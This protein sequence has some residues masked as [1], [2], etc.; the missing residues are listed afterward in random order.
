MRTE[1][2]MFNVLKTSTVGAYHFPIDFSYVKG[3]RVL[4]QEFDFAATWM[5]LE[6]IILSELSQLGKDKYIAYMWNIKK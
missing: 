3:S 6:F 2:R 5:N 4:S 1:Y